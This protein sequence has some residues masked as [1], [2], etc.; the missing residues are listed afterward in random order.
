MDLLVLCP[1]VVLCKGQIWGGDTFTVAEELA[2]NINIINISL[3]SGYK[4]LFV[5][6]IL[7]ILTP[8]EHRRD[9]TVSRTTKLV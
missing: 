2:K 5:S 3:L 6:N 7:R 1:K 9:G 8:L 4:I